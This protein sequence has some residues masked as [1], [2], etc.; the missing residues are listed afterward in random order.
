[1][2]VAILELFDAHACLTV[3]FLCF[4]FNLA[5]VCAV[6]FVCLDFVLDFFCSLRILMEPGV[7]TRLSFSNDP[8]LDVSI[9]KLVLCLTFKNRILY[10]YKN[11]STESKADIIDVKIF[12]VEFA[13]SLYETFFESVKVGAAVRSILSVYKREIDFVY[14]GNMAEGKL[15]VL[16]RIASYIIQWRFKVFLVL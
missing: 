11:C 10:L 14:A 16:A 9:A 15:Q 12:P 6:F 13:D 4:L 1:M 3:K 2:I 5:K 7:K 8:L